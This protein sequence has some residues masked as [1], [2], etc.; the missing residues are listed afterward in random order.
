M[1]VMAPRLEGVFEEAALGLLESMT[2]AMPE[3]VH[4]STGEWQVRLNDHDGETGNDV[5]LLAWLDEVLFRAQHEHKW[6]IDVS[7][8]LHSDEHSR[9]VR[10]AVRYVNGR[11]IQRSVEIKAVTS[12]SMMLQFVKPGERLL[13]IEGTVPE[14]IGPAWCAD[15]L[16]DV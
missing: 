4:V 3:A 15:V 16:L 11:S 10:A 1:R 13:G 5:L 7:L 14:L 6:L 9:S 2:P 12:H 8:G